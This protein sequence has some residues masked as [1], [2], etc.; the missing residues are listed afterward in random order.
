MQGQEVTL[1]DVFDAMT[2]QLAS[3][4]WHWWPCTPSGGPLRT[5]KEE[6][7]EDFKAWVLKTAKRNRNKARLQTCFTITEAPY[8][9]KESQGQ[10]GSTGGGT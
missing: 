8:P 9:G 10:V 4:H 7:V 3:G 6:A 2:N 1:Q 5:T